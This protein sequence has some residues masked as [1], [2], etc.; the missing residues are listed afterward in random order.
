[1]RLKDKI[2]IMDGDQ[3]EL[4]AVGIHIP[5]F[6]KLYVSDSSED[7]STYKKQLAYVYHMCEYDSPY[8]DSDTK[9]A[10]II[11]DFIGKSYWRKPKMVDAAVEAYKRLDNSPEKTTL[12]SALSACRSISRDIEQL[13]KSSS[14]VDKLIEELEK[15][16]GDDKTYD[17]MDRV[18]MAKMKLDL[19][20]D[21][22]KTADTLANIFSKL[23]KNIQTIVELRKK[24][25][26]AVYKGENAGATITKSFLID[27]LL[28]ELDNE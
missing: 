22:I 16:I 5:E 26:M 21:K 1:M 20:K 15:S 8:Y 11:R 25:T 23:D 6:Q 4:N 14:N 19:E 12:D 3:P 18:D 28:E 7:K 13:T 27:E 24:V 2:F 9:E 17:M 10:D